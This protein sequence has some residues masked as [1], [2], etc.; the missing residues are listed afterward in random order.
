MLNL[1]RA[2]QNVL[3]FHPKPPICCYGFSACICPFY[4]FLW[5]THTHTHARTQPH[6]VFMGVWIKFFDYCWVLAYFLSPRRDSS[7]ILWHLRLFTSPAA[8]MQFM[9]VGQVLRVWIF[10]FLIYFYFFAVLISFHFFILVYGF[11][12]MVGRCYCHLS[13]AWFTLIGGAKCVICVAC[14]LSDIIVDTRWHGPYITAA[15]H[16]ALGNVMY[17]Y[18]H[19]RVYPD[20]VSVDHKIF[21][22]V[23]YLYC[24]LWSYW[25]S[26]YIIS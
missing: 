1:I 11:H 14:Q 19:K 16:R 22:W 10:A 13:F 6:K 3:S 23:R 8:K 20:R 25:Q 24:L 21:L 7:L 9:C 26:P 15:S 2:V 5:F 4:L 17:K 18:L 12:F